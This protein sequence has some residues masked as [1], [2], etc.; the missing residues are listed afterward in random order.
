MT[1]ESFELLEIAVELDKSGK[2]DEAIECIERAVQIDPENPYPW[3]GLSMLLLKV[4][5]RSE[6]KYALER[7]FLLSPKRQRIC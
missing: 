7:A 5:R 1:K 3:Y 4:G 2:T 6:S